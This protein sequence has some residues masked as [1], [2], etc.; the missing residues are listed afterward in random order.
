[1]FIAVLLAVA[2]KWQQFKS[3]CPS[4]DEWIKKM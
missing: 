3:K 4:E 2:N 1:M